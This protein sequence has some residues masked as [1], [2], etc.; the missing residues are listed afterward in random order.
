MRGFYC[1]A[2]LRWLMDSVQ[3]PD[4]EAYQDMTN[5]YN[6]AFSDAVRGTRVSDMAASAVALD[7]IAYDF[8]KQVGLSREQYDNLFRHMPTTFASFYAGPHDPRP[9]IAPYAQHI[10]NIRSRGVVFATRTHGPR[11]S[12]V[13]VTSHSQLKAGQISD[14]LLHARLEDGK[15]KVSVFVV[16]D[17]F[18]ELS[19]IDE[20]H[21]P[22]RAFPELNTRLCYN[23]S[24][25]QLIVPLS[26]VVSHFAALVYT[27]DEIGQPCVVCHSLD[28]VRHRIPQ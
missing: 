13:F 3:W 1:G 18:E 12:Y 20:V 28:R 16:I 6:T 17:T 15:N 21:D 25:S 9:R 4:H 19:Q 24:D 10:P 7:D 2:E 14:I 5:A 8:K 22:F 27:P 23:R 26:D 11:D